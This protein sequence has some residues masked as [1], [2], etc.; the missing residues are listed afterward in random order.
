M[1]DIHICNR[2][3]NYFADGTSFRVIDFGGVTNGITQLIDFE[4]PETVWDTH[5]VFKR[6][7][8]DSIIICVWFHSFMCV[9][10][11]PFKI[12]S[13]LIYRRVLY[14]YLVVKMVCSR[15]NHEANFYPFIKIDLYDQFLNR[16]CLSSWF[17]PSD[18]EC[19]AFLFIFDILPQ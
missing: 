16:D 15:G 3:T 1:Q 10:L 6:I 13:K 2:K 19:F 4:C 12:F 9:R 17:L 14:S 7:S 18:Y 11:L 8:R 5:Y